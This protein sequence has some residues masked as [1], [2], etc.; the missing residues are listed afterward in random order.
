MTLVR[1]TSSLGNPRRLHLAMLGVMVVVGLMGSAGQA[2]PSIKLLGLLPLPPGIA[3]AEIDPG[4]ETIL[5]L[6]RSHQELVYLYQRFVDPFPTLA[7]YDLTPTV[8][9]FLRKITLSDDLEVFG[10][11]LVSLDESRRRLYVV[12]NRVHGSGLGSL[13]SVDLVNGTQRLQPLPFYPEGLTYSA[14]DDRIYLVG[15]SVPTIFASNFTGMRPAVVTLLGS[16]DPSDLLPVW[17]VPVPKCQQPMFAAFDDAG[18]P[19]YRSVG[20]RERYLFFPCVRTRAAPRVSAMVRVMMSGGDSL[21]DAIRYPVDVFPISGGYFQPPDVFVLPLQGVFSTARFEPSSNRIFLLSRAAH[22]HGAWVFDGRTSTW[23]GFIATPGSWGVAGISPFNCHIYLSEAVE[24][25]GLLV[26]D[27][28]ATPVPQGSVFPLSFRSI[29]GDP[30][31]NR[32]FGRVSEKTLGISQRTDWNSFRWAIYLDDS[33]SE[34]PAPQVDWDAQTVDVHEGDGTASSFA[35]G[36]T[37]FGSRIHLVGGLGGIKTQVAIV[38]VQPQDAGINPGDRD[39]YFGRISRLDL[40]DTGS[41]ATA[42]AV[43]ADSGTFNE[44]DTRPRTVARACNEGNVR[45]GTSTE[46]CPAVDPASQAVSDAALKPW[47]WSPAVCLVADQQAPDLDG[48]ARG[49]YG[50]QDAPGDAKV[51]CSLREQETHADAVAKAYEDDARQLTVA[52]SWSHAESHRRD[53]GTLE[54]IV[55]AAAESVEI[56][57]P[58]GDV[59]IGEVWSQATT[60]AHGRPKTASAR[61]ERH[62]SGIVI[63]RSGELPQ[64]LGDCVDDACQVQLFEINRQLGEF[65]RL[66]MPEAER[67]ATPRGAFAGVQK[68]LVDYLQGV[69]VYNDD[70]RAVPALQVTLYADRE[71]ALRFVAQFAAVES[72]SI[73]TIS[74]IAE[75]P[76]LSATPTTATILPST[77]AASSAGIQPDE[78]AQPRS[79]RGTVPR[80]VADVFAFI[81]RS[82]WEALQ[83]G[84]ILLLL[85][86]APASIAR[87]REFRSS[88]G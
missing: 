37:A 77:E 76:L 64:R 18:A 45:A 30:D 12:G 36:S 85:S 55:T 11:A 27:G 22:S 63:S 19:I 67:T 42:Q 39:V 33:P 9:T 3:R 56:H 32:F 70:A 51:H 86:A 75:T 87:R 10:S 69:T 80:L 66:D 81:V 46:V 6:D 68:T 47:P 43:A 13:L 34:Q 1:Q 74:K 54:T 58:V 8:P 62:L 53:D 38:D 2:D 88:I 60:A 15:E 52:K 73:Y 21:A 40:R 29:L 79:A 78:V 25:G 28:C 65:M 49:Q 84:V 72:T 5:A 26:A 57:T 20:L 16:V 44:W 31:S 4:R 7:I 61:W 17:I 50:D 48:E 24:G 83:F 71:Q 41:S 14:E 59:S 23:S 82:P 35:G